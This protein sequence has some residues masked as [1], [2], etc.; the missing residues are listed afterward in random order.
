L[1]AENKTDIPFDKLLGQKITIGLTLPTGKKRFF[2]GICNRFSQGRRDNTFTHYRME[3]VPQFWLLSRKMQCRIFQ[4]LSVP[5]ILKKV[6]DGL[7]VT[8]EIQGTFHPRDFCVQYRET[9][10]NFASRLM[11]EEGIFYFFKHSADGHKMVVANTP[12]SHPEV[13]EQSKI[14]YEEVKGGTREEMRITEW[15]KVQELRSG[16]YTLWDHCFELPHKHLEAE[17]T[18]VDSVQVAAPN[19]PTC[20]RS[21]KTINAPSKSACSKKRCL[22]CRFTAPATA[23]N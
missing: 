4:H 16:K 7:D 8:Y 13:P 10:F 18:I 21:L 20:K 11:E 3:V 15:E 12:Q 19:R 14:I 5:D 9:D 1:I 22:A 6:L 2:S 17:K 23:G